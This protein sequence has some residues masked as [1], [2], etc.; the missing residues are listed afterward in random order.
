MSSSMQ[1]MIRLRVEAQHMTAR[2]HAHMVAH[3]YTMYTYAC[4]R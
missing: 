2:D 4:G 3:G 1:C